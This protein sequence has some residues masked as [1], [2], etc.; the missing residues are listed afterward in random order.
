MGD[1]PDEAGR[2]VSED[3]SDGFDLAQPRDAF[4]VE[5]R[6]DSDMGLIGPAAREIFDLSAVRLPDVAHPGCRSKC[7]PMFLRDSL[8]LDVALAARPVLQQS[9]PEPRRASL[10]LGARSSDVQSDVPLPQL[11]WTEPRPDVP[12]RHLERQRQELPLFRL[13]LAKE[14]PGLQ[15]LREEVQMLVLQASMVLRLEPAL[16][17]GVRS[18]LWRPRSS[19]LPPP[20]PPQ[21]AQGNASVPVRR[22]RYQ[23]SSSE[24]SSL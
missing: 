9:L 17:Q 15:A 8:L 7:P 24:S 2:R 12:E 19:L 10:P 1:R 13:A 11:A 20:L 21:L 14:R 23:S 6:D 3:H 5:R 22:V 16:E 18:L 4:P